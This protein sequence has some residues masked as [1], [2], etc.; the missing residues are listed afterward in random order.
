MIEKLKDFSLVYFFC[1]SEN[2]DQQ[3]PLAI[4]KSWIYQA[5]IAHRDAFDLVFE[6]R[7]QSHSFATPTE[8]WTLFKAVASC[9]SE[10]VFVVD[11]FDECS[12]NDL[13][14]DGARKDFLVQLK[15]SIAGT[16]CRIALFSRNEVDIRSEIVELP[17]LKVYTH[18]IEKEDVK[19]DITTLSQSIVD[20][21]LPNKDMAVRSDL[22][23][24]MAHRCDGMFLWLR[25][26]G[27]RLHGGINRARL[28][29]IINDMPSGLN[30]A[31]ERD[32]KAI[33]DF[34]DWER[35]RAEKILLWTSFAVRPL[36]VAEITEALAIGDDDQLSTDELPDE[37]D[38]QYLDRSLLGLCGSLLELRAGESDDSLQSSTI[39]LV[40]FSV[41]EY[42]S[43]VTSGT[44]SH[45][46]DFQHN[47]LAMLC[48]RYLNYGN[49]WSSQG[50][51]NDSLQHPFLKYATRMW[52]KHIKEAGTNYPDVDKM[53]N[54]FLHPENVSF[55]KWSTYYES[56]KAADFS[57]TP[58]PNPGMPLYYSALFGLSNTIKQCLDAK[59]DVDAA[60][61]LYGTAIQ[62]ACAV[63]STPAFNLLCE[64][65]ASLN[66]ER[67]RYGS[68]LITATFL[69]R[70]DFA[71]RL[72]N[73]KARISVRDRFGRTPLF[74]AAS[75][76][77]SRIVKLLLKNG[78]DWS[79]KDEGGVAPLAVA[80]YCGHL[81]VVRILL[82]CGADATTTDVYGET[83]LMMAAS[84]GYLEMVQL[85]LK[86]GADLE[87]ASKESGCT[88][89]DYTVRNGHLEIVKLL[90]E[91]GASINS[92]TAKR[93]ST[94]CLAAQRGHLKVVQFLL[95]RGAD[96]NLTGENGWTPLFGAAQ[97]G[98]TDVVQLLLQHEACVKGAMND[99]QPIHFATIEG[100]LEIVKLLVDY[101]ADPTAPAESGSTPLSQAIDSDHADLA[102]FFVRHGAD[103]N[104]KVYDEI[105]LLYLAV[106]YE[107][108]NM[109]QFLLDNRAEPNPPEYEGCSLLGTAVSKGLTSIA[110]ILIENG[111]DVNA[112]TSQGFPPLIL[113]IV[114][115][116]V[117]AVKL[118]L[119]MGANV[120]IRSAFGLASINYASAR[121]F[122]DLVQYLLEKGAD[123]LVTTHGAT[124]LHFAVWYGQ[125]EVAKFLLE[126]NSTNI[127]CRTDEGRTALQIAASLR[128]NEIL[129]LLLE[130][131]VELDVVDR[132][133]ATALHWA[134]RYA[135]RKSI[136]TLISHGA[137]TRIHDCFG[138]TAQDWACVTG[139]SDVWADLTSTDEATQRRL[140]D[141]S[142]QRFAGELRLNL[143]DVSLLQNL[144][145]CFLLNNDLISAQTSFAQSIVI[146]NGSS[147]ACSR[148]GV[149]LME[150][151]YVCKSCSDVELCE[152]CLAEYAAGQNLR[153][154]SGHDFLRIEV[155]SKQGELE[156]QPWID[157]VV[158]K[159]ATG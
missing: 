50:S 155:D 106:H 45:N 118:L 116:Q 28:Q 20:S 63:S 140:R 135:E 27:N 87:A 54:N 79:M 148:C 92:T 104:Q 19:D 149:D 37:I 9:L 137:S 55:I 68:C 142:I 141:S 95:E 4:I 81:E 113:A 152:T 93:T 134:V 39:H 44:L 101:G 127:N 47:Q 107:R 40:H 70:D 66:F 112:E 8:V 98:H 62:A 56:E 150:K 26:Q 48:L 123:V 85:L 21:K 129:Q 153:C 126:V 122:L 138:R 105:P 99:Y 158:A 110:K 22:A 2:E 16:S 108:T 143:Q 145:R 11:G 103:V 41:R 94:L 71:E 147:I 31:Y 132:F 115:Y 18:R 14:R 114:N 136:E 38:Q 5:A 76:G 77:S 74:Y 61:G 130:Y 46:E 52:F 57:E 24:Q 7:K 51:T 88:S 154:C 121:G 42:L 49:T 111:S 124:P 86:H 159:Y 82:D 10:F 78:A 131:Q 128:H 102:A 100:H 3:Q 119:E 35:E 125:L 59:V 13:D 64:A 23:S 33:S 69:G 43:S 91:N 75:S 146:D 72:I 17:G 34:E 1:S 80:A 65:G 157:E 133:G 117:D 53:V 58:P 29:K 15:D 96:I 6:S 97:R 156:L 12:W 30:H 73:M 84:D 151:W 90:L 120:S 144:G 139:C 89:L 83:P 32:W 25:L 109:V 60:G 67:G 36:T